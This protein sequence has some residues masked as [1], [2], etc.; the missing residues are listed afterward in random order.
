M[1]T[2]F[3]ATLGAL[4]VSTTC[5]LAAGCGGERAGHP[6]SPIGNRSKST[7]EEI[8]VARPASPPSL[9]PPSATSAS[10]S[11][12]SARSAVNPDNDASKDM[13][14]GLPEG[15]RGSV[16]IVVFFATWAE[17]AKK[18]LPKLDV[19]ASR[20]V[21]IVGIDEDEEPD[22]VASFVSA[23]GV[24]FPWVFDQDRLL[25]QGFH[26]TSMPAVYVLARSGAIRFKHAGYRD[27]MEADI[28][29]E[30]ALLLK[31]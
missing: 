28:A 3:R 17:P 4:V 30:V 22:G 25:A 15:V 8:P 9:P 2:L 23:L 31:E 26:V 21:A 7:V 10:T 6:S 29:R 16:V 24:S 13:T 19:M 20:G 18:L 27:G 5:A 14:R 1:A 12:P 11:A